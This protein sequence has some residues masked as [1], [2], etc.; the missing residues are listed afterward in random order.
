MF[1]KITVIFAN[2][3]LVFLL[4]VGVVILV[5]FLPLKRN[6]KILT[7]TS[8]SM[9]PVLKVGSAVVVRGADDYQPGQIITFRAPEAKAEKDY[10]THRVV[11]TEDHSDGRY[12]VTRG[13]ANDAPDSVPIAASAVVGRVLFDVP[14]IGYVLSY[15]KTLPGLLILVIVPATIIVYE[16]ARK[17]RDEAH[18]S[19][20]RRRARRQASLSSKGAA[21]GAESADKSSEKKPNGADKAT[22][23]IRAVGEKRTGSK[24]KR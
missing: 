22:K 18:A 16:E 10:I 17:I 2:L 14:Y 19:M 6:F 7:V 13:D 9:E 21:K 5:S 8:G 3:I 15:I 23:K 1:K 24:R 12:Y 4:A 20:A 11:S